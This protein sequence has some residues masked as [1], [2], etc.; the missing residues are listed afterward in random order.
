MIDKDELIE[1][2]AKVVKLGLEALPDSKYYEKE[3]K[4]SLVWEECTDEEQEKVKEIRTELSIALQIYE[5]FKK[6]KK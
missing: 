3:D 4:I 6:G 2:L 1:L 5:A